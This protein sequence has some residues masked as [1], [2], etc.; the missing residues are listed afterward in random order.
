MCTALP[1]ENH[2]QVSCLYKEM[3]TLASKDNAYSL[4]DHVSFRQSAER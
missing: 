1:L 4:F 3:F 2:P